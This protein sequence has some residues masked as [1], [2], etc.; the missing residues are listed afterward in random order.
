[1]RSASKPAARVRVLGAG[2]AVAL[3]AALTAGC[4]VA[5]ESS[6]VVDTVKE[7]VQESPKDKL[8]AAGF[9][10]RGSTAAALETLG[11]QD[12][13]RFGKIAASAHMTID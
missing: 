7:A 5:D 4:G 12:Y 10:P 2:V 3:C 9:A 8:V 11:R 13:E 6:S 1:M